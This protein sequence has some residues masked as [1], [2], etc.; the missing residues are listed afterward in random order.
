M[1]YLISFSPPP[2]KR[3]AFLPNTPAKR[4]FRFFGGK[5][6]QCEGKPASGAL[7]AIPC[8]R[9]PNRFT[10]IT[11]TFASLTSRIRVSEIQKEPT[12]KQMRWV[13]LSLHLSHLLRL[14]TRSARAQQSTRYV[15]QDCRSLR[16]KRRHF[17]LRSLYS[18]VNTVTP[19]KRL[20]F[21]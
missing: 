11:L 10:H 21:L 2:C 17:F 12:M 1:S 16:R 18:K 19:E 4:R 20:K 15:I 6:H 13:N 9:S 8:T 14:V 3:R 5:H 7:T